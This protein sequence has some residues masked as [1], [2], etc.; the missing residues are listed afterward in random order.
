M[1]DSFDQVTAAL[2]TRLTDLRS[3]AERLSPLDIHARMDA[4]RAEADRA[5]LHA[6]EGLASLSAQLAL[7]PGCR[8][9]TGA[10]LDHAADALAARTA[11]ERQA[12]LAV[13][14]TRLH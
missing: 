8:V 5:G 10:C 13:V 6:L 4:I 1:P 7:L 2:T 14:A 12:V 9:R 3:S 11:A